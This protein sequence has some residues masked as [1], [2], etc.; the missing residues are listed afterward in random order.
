[1]LKIS[2]DKASQQRVGR[3]VDLWFI[4]FGDLKSLASDEFLTRQIGLSGADSDQENGSRVKLLSDADLARRG[5]PL[6][7]AA[8]DPRIV[9]AESTLLDRVRLTVTTRNVRTVTDQSVCVASILDEHF[10]SDKEFPNTW[11]PISRDNSGRRQIGV[12]QPYIGMG[13]YVKATRLVEPAGA[14]FIEYHLAFAE[15]REWFQGT[16]LLRSKLPIVAQDA[17]RK[18]RRSLDK[19]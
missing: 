7:K 3:R 12:P 9:A 10:S 13:S 17:V 6:P 19:E 14:L 4:A 2:D 16:N 18:F 1:M 15:P 8:S 5:L 11:S